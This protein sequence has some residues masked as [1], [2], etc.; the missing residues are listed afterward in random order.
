MR[1]FRVH[2]TTP[3]YLEIEDRR[4]PTK[5]RAYSVEG[6]RAALYAACSDEAHSATALQRLLQLDWSVADI[7]SALVEFQS[8]GLMMREDQR[9]LS[10]ALPASRNR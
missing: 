8:L 4:N 9:F 7:E 3:G 10:L 5:P 6:P 2:V 1:I